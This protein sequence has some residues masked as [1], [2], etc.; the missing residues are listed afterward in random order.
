MNRRPGVRTSLAASLATLTMVMVSA[1]S[2]GSVG[3]RHEIYDSL[4]ALIA[5]STAVVEVQVEDRNSV[6]AREDS[7][8][9]TAATVVV[10]TVMQPRDLSQTVD[11][12]SRLEVG[13]TVVIRQM[14]TPGTHADT[15]YLEPG[16]R[17]LVF[18]TPTGVP[19]AAA[20]EFY[21]TGANAGIYRADADADG[22]V[23]SSH[24]EDRLPEL[25]TLK[26][27]E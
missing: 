21:I 27:L 13:S 4:S 23:R 26:D 16:N 7:S 18:L 11:V 2:S 8:A 6:A 5:D 10:V 15:P 1:C 3:S 20:K 9:Y 22:F 14:G 24:D 17:Y 19:N 25:L 12:P